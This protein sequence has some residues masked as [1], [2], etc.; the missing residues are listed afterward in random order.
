MGFPNIGSVVWTAG[1]HSFVLFAAH[2]AGEDG[3]TITD[4]FY[5]HLQSPYQS[6]ER[7]IEIQSSG[8]LLSVLLH[9]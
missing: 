5:A 8:L 3:K 7:M 1:A 9:N 2:L 4:Y 6:Q